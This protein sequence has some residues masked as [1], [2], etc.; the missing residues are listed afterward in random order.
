MTTLE[1][2][3]R[4]VSRA[5]AKGVPVSA[6]LGYFHVPLAD[7]YPALLTGTMFGLMLLLIFALPALLTRKPLRPA[8]AAGCALAGLLLPGLL[9]DT[10]HFAWTMLALVLA[11]FLA[12]AAT[13]VARI[14]D[15]TADYREDHQ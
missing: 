14:E 5:L 4:S 15:I 10:N 2:I 7:V 11:I 9:A 12:L 3:L 1:L 6:L 8:A 13:V